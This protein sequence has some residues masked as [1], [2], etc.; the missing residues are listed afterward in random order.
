V[1]LIVC[2]Q[3]DAIQIS[4]PDN[5]PTTGAVGAE[6]TSNEFLFKVIDP[7]IAANQR[8]NSACCGIRAG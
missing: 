4:T 8:K 1:L 3:K 7:K 2:L 5:L 6:D